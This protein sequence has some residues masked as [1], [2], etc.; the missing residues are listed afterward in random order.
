MQNPRYEAVKLLTKIEKSSS[1]SAILISDA[2]KD[3]K[4]SN[5]KDTSFAVAI[6]YGVLE[7]RITID[8]NISLYLSSKI[9]KLKPDVLN[10]L[11]AGAYQILYADK[12]PDS[13]AVN[14]AVEIAKKSG[15][16]YSSGLVNAVLRKISQNGLK[17]PDNDKSNFYL[18]VLYS[19][20]ESIVGKMVDDYGYD[21]A[22]EIM[23]S[24]IGRRPIYIRANTL[25]C[26]DSDLI[27]SLEKDGVTVNPTSLPHCYS[28]SNSGDITKLSAFSEGWFYVQD[29]S[30]QLCCSLMDIVPGQTIVDCCAAP[31]GK[32]FS[33]AQYLK[34]SG[35]IISCDMYEHKARLISDGAERL[36]IT[37]L[38]AVCSDARNLKDKI[39][40]ADKVLCDVPCSG[41]GVMGRKPEIRYKK[42]S[43][44]T[45]IPV[46]QKEILYSCCSIV[47][48]GGTLIYSTCTLNKD[49]NENICDDF[50][51]DHPEFSIADDEIYRS[52]TDR[53][54]TVFPS[55]NGGD[56]FFI[57]KFIR[58]NE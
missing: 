25:K 8:Y 42:M 56:G 6:I 16:S 17:L 33:M 54:I 40:E 46:I 52:H 51:R 41:F 43:E 34:N 11:R 29:M 37:V 3:I 12:I 18:S 19:V 30:S 21:K 32:S 22:V 7:N 36:G 28:V 1:Y 58:G 14:E 49:E 48:K 45:E 38:D 31:G 2:F 26:N 10:N 53:Y 20:D 55:E 5:S 9:T 4:F 57:A 13:A 15:A 47:R 24:F 44:L 23:E 50:L 39:S 27:A 35:K